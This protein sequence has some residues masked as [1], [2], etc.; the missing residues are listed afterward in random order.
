[1]NTQALSTQIVRGSLAEQVKSH[2]TSLALEWLNVEVIALV[3][4]SGSMDERDA[5]GNRQRYAVACEEMARVQGERPGKVAVYAFSD[6]CTFAPGG[7]P[8]YEGHGTNLAGALR[9]L[10]K[11]CQGVSRLIVISDGSPNSESDALD[12][13]AKI[14]CQIDTV[15]IGDEGDSRARQFLE[16]LAQVGRGQRHDAPHADGLA[17]TVLLLTAG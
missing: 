11:L 1:M 7:V 3:D 16:R 9:T 17:D 13:A 10:H 4:V 14:T 6:S 2:G 8:A 5:R 15:Y 12:A